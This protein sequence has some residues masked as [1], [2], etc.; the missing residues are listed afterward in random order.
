MF[1]TLE[2][3]SLRLLDEYNP[4]NMWFISAS[5]E[6]HSTV[7]TIYCIERVGILQD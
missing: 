4:A 5:E 2:T 7:H 3:G 6:L 1:Q